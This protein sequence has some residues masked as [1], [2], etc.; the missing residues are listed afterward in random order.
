MNNLIQSGKITA[1]LSFFIGTTLLALYLY[2]DQPNAIEDI[3]VGFVLFALFF[4][5]LLFLI[6]LGSSVIYQNYRFE[7]LKVCGI[8]ILNIPIAIAYF[9]FIL[10]IEF[11]TS[12]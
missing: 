3:G 12:V 10:T 9:Y 5:S 1:A 11:P 8:M 4:N 7:L 2:F 6:L